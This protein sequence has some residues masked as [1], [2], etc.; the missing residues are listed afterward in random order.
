M[1]KY[2]VIITEKEIYVIEG[3]EANNKNEA[4]NKAW[5]MLT[6]MDDKD[7]YHVDSDGET[8]VDEVE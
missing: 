2:N 7:K 5:E 1:K 3:I 6:S 4:S 8:E